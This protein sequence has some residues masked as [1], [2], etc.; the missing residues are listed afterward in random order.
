MG[1]ENAMQMNCLF[2]H[3]VSKIMVFENM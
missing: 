2:F 3:F 1:A